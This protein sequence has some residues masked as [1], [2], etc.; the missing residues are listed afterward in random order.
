[1]NLNRKQLYSVIRGSLTFGLAAG[2][3]TT[4][5]AQ[6]EAEDESAELDKILVTGSR[7]KQ[8]DVETA[9]PVTI[10]NREDI[11]MS[12]DT[13]VAEVLRNMSTNTFGSWRGVSGYGSG[14]PGSV[15]VDLRG[16]GATLVLIDG[17]RMPGAGYDGGQTQNLNNI[18]LAIVERI[19]VLRGGA[20]A[21]YGSDAIGG[22]VNVITLKEL[23]GGSISYLREDRGVDDGNTDQWEF[24]AGV[25]GDKG[26]MLVTFQ[27]TEFDPL[28][29][30]AV[31]GFDNG[32]SWWGPV[33]NVFYASQSALAYVSWYPQELCETIPNTVDQGFRCGYAY[34]NVTWLYP[35]Q[36]RDSI[37]T[38]I[39][40]ELTP[41]I[42]FHARLAF[43]G[44]E[45]QSRFA[46]TPVST[47]TIT[48]RYDNPNAP[49]EVAADVISGFD[50]YLY[51]Y[52]RTAL[53][54]TRDA[55]F[56]DN[57]FDNVFGLEGY[58]DAF[59]GLDWQVN[60][61]YTLKDEDVHN[62]NL[63]NDILFQRGL[64]NGQFDIFNVAG[65]PADEWSENAFQFYKTVAHTGIYEVRNE[66]HIFDGSIGGELFYTDALSL[67]AVVGGEFEKI[68]FTQISDPQSAAGFVSGGAGGNDVYATRE[69]TSLYGEVQLN[70]GFGV[71][72]S[73]A[74]RYDEYDQDG[75]TTVGIVNQSSNKVFDDTTYMF[76]AAWRP[77]DNILIRG[78]IGTAFR[79]PTMSQLFSSRS[80]GFPSAYDYYYCDTLGNPGGNEAYC[81]ALNP[82]QIKTFSGGN[83]TLEPENADTMTFGGV[84]NI[85]DDLSVEIQY[86]DIEYENKIVGVSLND[87]LLLNQAAGGTTAQVVRNSSGT[88]EYIQ[89]GVQNF[90]KQETNGVDFVANYGLNTNGV[91]N[92]S[93]SLQATHV[94]EFTDV[95]KDALT[96]AEIPLERAGNWGSPDWRANWTMGWSLGNFFASW[97]ANYIGKQDK[98]SG[99]ASAEDLD[100]VTYHNL[101][102]GWYAPWDGE[103]TV[104]V[105]NVADE[106]I[107][108]NFGSPSWRGYD[109]FLYS[110]EGR[111]WY[112][113][114]KQNF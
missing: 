106:D 64:D 60:Y 42:T 43:V 80:F 9:Q 93:F 88:I 62:T 36:Q 63:V 55:F 71:E 91:G 112:A 32:T 101:Q 89:S 41:N 108:F 66:R 7:I 94:I 97:R 40:Y 10:I 109:Y 110:P 30:N 11:D 4:G 76:T 8:V 49:A 47:N 103:I 17:R 58:V 81:D 5:W 70:L 1:M 12:G 28:E 19:E 45:T 21:I 33:T 114:Y 6:D 61:Q 113:R 25:T 38:K 22:V 29:D 79:A 57:T 39:N 75:I 26:N 31:S 44:N 102:A 50:P 105:R 53:L 3:T 77:T 100:A 84:W 95:D 59:N 107:Q 72:L 83:P 18:P 82:P 48:M 67:S 13:S 69:R 96:G 2:L 111:T 54:G 73:G 15:E 68:D 51:I 104:G 34:S 16:V 98:T 14:A 46:P 23:D 37:M 35:K 85:T 52:H 99:A 90:L 27:H 74:V 24:A 87:I 78:V 86:Y 20:S 92:F 65:L 56:T